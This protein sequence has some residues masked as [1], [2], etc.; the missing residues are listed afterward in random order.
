MR[1][2]LVAALGLFA[3]AGPGWAAPGLADPEA[4]L[5]ELVTPPETAAQLDLVDGL[6]FDPFG[7]LF[8]A[9]EIPGPRGGLVLVDPETGR[10][11][12][13]GGGISRA[14]QVALLNLRDRLAT[15]LVTSEVT[16]AA[17]SQR[18]FATGV[19]YDADG[20]PHTVTLPASVSTP[21]AISN[22]EGLA[23]IESDGRF[24]AAGTVYVAEDLVGGRILRLEA[25]RSAMSVL[26]GGLRR[27]EGLAFGDFGAAEEPA[28][29]A[30]ETSLHRVIRI[31]PAGRVSPLGAPT[32]VG[33][34]NPDNV[35]FGPDGF[36]YVTEDRPAP[37]SRIVRV[38][39]DGTHEVF[40]TGFGQAAGLAFHPETGDLYVAEQDF[41]RI[42]RVRFTRE[43]AIDVRPR[44]RY[45]RV[46]PG[47]RSVLPV[48][49]LG[50][51]ELDTVEI[52]AASLAFGPG[53]APPVHAPPHRVDL[54][55]DGHTDLLLHFR[56]D[57][58]GL[59]SGDAEVCLRGALL[60]GRPLRGCDAIATL[61]PRPPGP[62]PWALRAARVPGR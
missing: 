16:P 24:G 60:D 30:A 5:L 9:L 10:V 49:I 27:P 44:S 46:R 43:V 61:P 3:S 55:R 52:D 19:F 62:P 23:V 15:L 4:G 21:L 38:A 12:G 32:E 22:P 13:L 28:L 29:Y 51:E 1:R 56:V 8:A 7:N 6:A 53:G 54:D 2:L 37:Q 39:V 36:L 59:A 20:R 31:D 41:D 42:W 40:A 14:D 35:E 17:T 11:T 58:S 34:T 47:T 33:L 18:L 26:V 57:A 48:A 50:S 45:N 25:D